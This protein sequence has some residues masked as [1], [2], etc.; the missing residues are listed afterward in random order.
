MKKYLLLFSILLT[1]SQALDD[2]SYIGVS[3]DGTINMGSLNTEF[4]IGGRFGSDI[5]ELYIYKL[6]ND[7]HEFRV[8]LGISYSE[9]DKIQVAGSILYYLTDNLDLELNYNGK[10]RGGFIWYWE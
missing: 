7:A 2:F 4:Y 3:S 5:R 9:E 6:L 1:I 10:F 8:A